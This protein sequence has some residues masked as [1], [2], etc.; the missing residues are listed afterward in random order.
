MS[1]T[2]LFYPK[3]HLYLQSRF[4]EFLARLTMVLRVSEEDPAWS[5]S[6]TKLFVSVRLPIV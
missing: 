4:I 5:G 3:W 2:N 1:D 6:L